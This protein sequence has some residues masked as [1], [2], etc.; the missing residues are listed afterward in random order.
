MFPRY[1]VFDLDSQKAPGVV[2][3]MKRCL[4]VLNPPHTSSVERLLIFHVEC[5]KT[6]KKMSVPSRKIAVLAVEVAT[7][8]GRKRPDRQV[9]TRR[10]A[11]NTSGER[12]PFGYA[13]VAETFDETAKPTILARFQA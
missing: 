4:K 9:Q 12:W 11:I 10:I 7:R 5:P 1:F 3:P 6:L 8:G 2:V 13:F